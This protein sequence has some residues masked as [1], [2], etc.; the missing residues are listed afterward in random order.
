MGGQKSNDNNSIDEPST[1][2]E[3]SQQFDLM[4]K[5]FELNTL[6]MTFQNTPQIN[7]F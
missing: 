4:S 1:F 6:E 7:E 3:Q 5:K 2:N